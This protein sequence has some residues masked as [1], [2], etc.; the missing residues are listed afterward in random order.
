M[1]FCNGGKYPPVR[2]HFAVHGV[3]QQPIAARQPAIG[4]QFHA[5]I[6]H[7]QI[8]AG[9][10]DD[11]QAIQQQLVG[12]EKLRLDRRNFVQGPR[13]HVDDLQAPG[14][15]QLP[16]V[17]QIQT[18][19][20]LDSFL[21]IRIV[22]NG[23]RRRIVAQAIETRGAVDIVDDAGTERPAFLAQPAALIL[24]IE[25]AFDA[26]LGA[27]DQRPLFVAGGI[28]IDAPVHT[29]AELGL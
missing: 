29:P 9:V 21:L 18:H 19:L 12:A 27:G 4:D 26:L 5:A 11:G 6:G 8:I 7:R 23:A 24:G 16:R 25:L 1:V 22:G 28:P 20:H 3:V 13:E 14:I 10:I 15:A 17:S 2:A